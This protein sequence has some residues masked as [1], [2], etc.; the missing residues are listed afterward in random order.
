MTRETVA[1][2]T[3]AN[4]ETSYIVAMKNYYTPIPKN[5]KHLGEFNGFKEKCKRLHS[6]FDWH[7]LQ[8]FFDN[9]LLC[10]IVQS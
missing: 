3:P 6:I 2:D 10:P 9:G 8:K 5:P 4:S 1:S 7:N